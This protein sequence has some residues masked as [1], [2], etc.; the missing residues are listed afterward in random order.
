MV[1]SGYPTNQV[2]HR[3]DT[4]CHCAIYTLDT[5]T[6]CN[7][8]SFY[9]VC[10]TAFLHNETKIFQVN[11]FQLIQTYN[12]HHHKVNEESAAGI[13]R[14]CADP[15]ILCSKQ[16]INGKYTDFVK[17]LITR[18]VMLVRVKQRRDLWSVSIYRVRERIYGVLAFMD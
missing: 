12:A 8:E 18:Y 17:T 14:T 2:I 4:G 11:L 6:F 13:N 16:R 3:D 10:I 7:K 5:Y 15:G 9:D 1:E